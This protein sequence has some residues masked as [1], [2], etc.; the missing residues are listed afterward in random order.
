MSS[1]GRCPYPI[2][3]L[4]IMDGAF[5]PARWRIGAPE[6]TTPAGRLS[7]AF[8]PLDAVTPAGRRVTGAVTVTLRLRFISAQWAEVIMTRHSTTPGLGAAY[9]APTAA[10]Q[11]D[12]ISR[13][14]LFDDEKDDHETL[15]VHLATAAICHMV[16]SAVSASEVAAAVL[17]QKENPSAWNHAEFLHL[18]GLMAHHEMDVRLDEAGLLV[19][20]G[21]NQVPAR[22]VDL[23][24][25]RL[26]VS[27][28]CR[29]PSLGRGLAVELSIEL[30]TSAAKARGIAR[31]LNDLE[32]NWVAGPPLLGSWMVDPAGERL[33]FAS[34]WPNLMHVPNLLPRI[35]IWQ[36]ERLGLAI[37]ALKY[38]TRRRHSA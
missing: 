17:P 2:S 3:L 36:V 38:I 13:V 18:A 33:L 15:G 29:H 1:H 5:G 22:L 11:V 20:L 37:D 35:A 28:S 4:E 25:P 6:W 10:K 26:G 30:N 32:L 8:R 21:D 9:I 34:F 16:S 23:T 31:Q 24:S 12:V 27:A 7:A 14:W 19:A